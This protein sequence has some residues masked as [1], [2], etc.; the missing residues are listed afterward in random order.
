MYYLIV[1]FSTAKKLNNEKRITCKIGTITLHCALQYSKDIGHF[2]YI[3]KENQKKILAAG[4]DIK[5]AIF[6]K[7]TSIHQFKIPPELKEVLATDPQ[8][9]KV[10]QTLT[11]GGKRSLMYLAEQPKSI[12]KKIE[13]ALLIANRLKE[14]VTSARL[15]LKK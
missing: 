1:P 5:N 3:G 13:R 6:S 4:V 15:I 11:P 7:D 8:A 9:N 14:G 12:D 10:F 2:V